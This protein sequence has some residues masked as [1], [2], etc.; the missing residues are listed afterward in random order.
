MTHPLSSA[1]ISIFSTEIS[2]FCYIK[3]YRYRFHS[4]L[5]YNSGMGGIKLAQIFGH[6]MPFFSCL[7]S[8]VWRISCSMFFWV[9]INDCIWMRP[10]LIVFKQ[11]SYQSS[12]LPCLI[13]QNHGKVQGRTVH[14]HGSSQIICLNTII[15][16]YIS[17]LL[18]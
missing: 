5:I 2:N 16:N 1:G 12:C 3:K 7:D 13:C 8:D 14:F 6:H 10:M 17:N 15:N 4:T 18:L 11:S 9:L